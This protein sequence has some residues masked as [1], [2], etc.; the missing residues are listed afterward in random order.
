MPKSMS[1]TQLRKI[2]KTKG[3]KAAIR[4]ARESNAPAAVVQLAEDLDK[5]TAPG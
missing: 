3:T 5:V 4:I 2:V 1:K